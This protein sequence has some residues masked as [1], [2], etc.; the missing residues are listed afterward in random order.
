M[1]PPLENTHMTVLSLPLWTSLLSSSDVIKMT[2]I[3]EAVMKKYGIIGLGE[4]LMMCTTWVGV[5][6]SVDVY[7]SQHHNCLLDESYTTLVSG[8]HEQLHGMASTQQH[9]SP[10]LQEGVQLCSV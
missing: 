1:P 3:N 2:S 6:C 9:T 10:T 8:H 4:S 5:S 7:A